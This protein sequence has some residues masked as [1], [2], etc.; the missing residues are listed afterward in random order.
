[1]WKD[2]RIKKH[3]PM[4]LENCGVTYGIVI[5]DSSLK[6]SIGSLTECV[7]LFGDIDSFFIVGGISPLI[8]YAN[9]LRILE[10]YIVEKKIVT[11]KLF[12]G[13]EKIY[14]N[15]NRLQPV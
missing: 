6:S 12:C 11:V 4:Q 14:L 5:S 8:N 10:K 15:D 13:H 9:Q 3:L 1:V 7:E 2:Y